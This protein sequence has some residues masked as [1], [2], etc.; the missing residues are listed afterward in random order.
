MAVVIA[1]LALP[2]F[3]G[4]ADRPLSITQFLNPESLAIITVIVISI[5]ILAGLYP[6][7]F[8][9][10]FSPLYVLKGRLKTSQGGISLR[11]V[12]VVM[13]FAISITLISATLIVFNQMN[14]MLNK[15]L[16]FEKENVIVIENAGVLNNNNQGFNIT[17]FETFK[18]EINN[19]PNVIS[20]A[21]TSNMPG[22]QTGEGRDEK[23]RVKSC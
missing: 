17:R 11:N 3:N 7:F 10:S 5:G 14:F 12:L 6:A 2:Q 21:F 22:D 23:C 13:Q 18:T 1:Y 9:S 4:L 16:G 15:P 19:L 8:I 20:S